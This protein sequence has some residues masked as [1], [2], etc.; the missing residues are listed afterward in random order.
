MVRLFGRV[1]V[2]LF[3]LVM[4][5]WAATK[6]VT[7]KGSD[8][9]V[10][11]AQRWAEAYMKAHPGAIVQVTG[12]GSGTGIAALINGA[13]DIAQASRPMKP[14]FNSVSS[15]PPRAPRCGQRG[16]RPTVRSIARLSAPALRTRPI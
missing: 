10:I 8:T 9:M 14:E 15:I 4:P 7:V 11:L 3:L 2:S 6:S 1:I 16:P 12:G 13:T 5:A